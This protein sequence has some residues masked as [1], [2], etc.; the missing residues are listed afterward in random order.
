MNIDE[1]I[2]YVIEAQWVLPGNEFY[3]QDLTSKWGFLKEEVSQ[4]KA[5]LRNIQRD[6]R[7]YFF[8]VAAVTR[9]GSSSFV[10]TIEPFRLSK[11]SRAETLDVSTRLGNQ[12]R[13]N[14][15]LIE[16]PRNFSVKDLKLHSDQMNLTLMWQPPADAVDGYQLS[17]EI[18][19]SSDQQSVDLSALE[20]TI[21]FLSMEKSYLFKVCP[22]LPLLASVDSTHPFRFVRY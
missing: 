17:W 8:R 3:R 4:S 15:S 22:F 2:F 16:A 9:H 7:S 21:P 20:I 5:I 19:N 1:P 11:T 12:S 14:P 6:Q 10:S 13:R 18:E